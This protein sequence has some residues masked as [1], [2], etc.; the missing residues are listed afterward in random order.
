MNLHPVRIDI[1][2]FPPGQR[3]S[4][5]EA[6]AAQ[7]FRIIPTGLNA[8]IEFL[9]GFTLFH[10]LALIANFNPTSYLNY[11]IEIGFLV[12]LIKIEL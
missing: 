8:P 7:H 1:P 12:C 11:F 5:P 6:A 2:L 10:K 3:P 4:G 9:T